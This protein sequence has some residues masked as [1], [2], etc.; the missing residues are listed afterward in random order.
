MHRGV[1]LGSNEDEVGYVK[2]QNG[3]LN[4]LFSV[5]QIIFFEACESSVS[6]SRGVVLSES[7]IRSP[8]SARE[9]CVSQ[10]VWYGCLRVCLLV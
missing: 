3:R 1:V 7:S 10:Y 9:R 5:P 6:R 4:H 8:S 2:K